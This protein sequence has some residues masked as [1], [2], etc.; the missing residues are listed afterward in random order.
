M[1]PDLTRKRAV[2]SNPFLRRA[3]P[4]Q[5]GSRPIHARKSVL[6]R[7]GKQREMTPNGGYLELCALVRLVGCGRRV[8]SRVGSAT[9]G[10]SVISGSP[11]RLYVANQHAL[12]ERCESVGTLRHEFL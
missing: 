6:F 11:R 5:G 8:S 2:Q 12:L 1:C 4:A 3:N 7:S 10:L 9:D